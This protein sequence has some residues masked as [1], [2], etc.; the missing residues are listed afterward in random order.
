MLHLLPTD[1]A[2][3]K[4]S[5]IV[6][7]ALLSLIPRA[8]QAQ[9][10]SDRTVLEHFRDSLTSISDS[11]GLLLLEK[12][13]ID[14]AKA[15]RN[16]AV[17]H[18]KLGFVSLRLGEMGGHSHYDDAASEFQWAIDLQPSWPYAWYG[19][20]LAEYGVGDSQ[21]SFVTGLKTMLG[22]D[23]LTRSAVA[24]AKSAEVD[25][26][27]ARGLVDLANTALRQRVNIKL[28]VALDALRRAGKTVAGTDP[29]VLLA[30]GRVEREV[31]DGDSA[32]A[33]FN[34][35]L[36]Y[37][38]N[39]SLG[40]LELAR[41]HF[42]L[43]RF[44][45]VAA[46]FE[47]AAAD[48]STTVASYRSDL[49]TIA[50][51]STLREF[52]RQRGPQRVAYLKR[53]W[54]QRDRVELRGD[55]ERLRE[56]YRRLFYARKNFQLTTNNRHYDIVER[57]RSGSRDFDDRGVIYIRHGEPSS[58]ATYAAPGL[59]PNESWRYIRPD[60]D[61]I[62]HFIAR[63]DVQDFK[64]VESLFDVLG[65]SSAV[66]LQGQAAG[67]AENAMASQLMLSREQLSPIYRRL[68]GAGRM[69]TGRY[70][71]QERRVGQESIAVGT[72]S[73]SYELRF[74]QP[75]KARS[76]VLA[77]GRDSNG[78]Q[79]Q[80][81]YAIAGSSLEP[82]TVTR[83]YLY[84]VRL[85]FVALDKRGQVVSSLDTTRHFVAPAP[86]PPKEHL[87]GRVGT[88]VPRGALRYRLAIQQGAA[89]GVSLPTDSVRVGPVAPAALSLSDL[90]LGSRSANL[91]WRR[92]PGDTV[93]FNPLRTYRRS[94]EME[95]YYEIDG[96]RPSPY[97]VEL[98]VKRKGSSG[99]L[100]RKIFG[101]GGAAIRLKFQ[102]QATTPQVSTHRRLQLNRLKPGNYVLEI[103]VV[104]AAGRK[105][106]R[107][108]EF[109]VVE[110][111]KKAG[112][113]GS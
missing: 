14:S 80:I 44:D 29:E 26:S 7:I 79:V 98:V 87:V 13:L 93:L 46:Y 45:G 90:V 113:R 62:F 19:M 5:G 61:L 51:D 60:G 18:L 74:P 35:Y 3:W 40:L 48:D 70:Q 108:R 88:T 31:G 52:D 82:V 97:T 105:D 84:S 110:E 54:T 100:F 2:P 25:P 83:G 41:T 85:R 111:E 24:F 20:G 53:F 68:Q 36:Q 37:G 59:D 1:S 89:A 75:L 50:A 43:G 32:L 92:T 38:P 86:V 57:Y 47:G 9:T 17:L 91:A 58:R 33:A 69:S 27:F 30:R 77:V 102:E 15:D 73:D 96:L 11:S 106:R 78:P 66:K 65:F 99:G 21:V 95:L 67:A 101:G 71:S 4:H 34:G 94:D 72:T 22:K 103:L 39:R 10:P 64:L 56:H 76:E 8:I 55:G 112:Q 107:T 104:D 16:N 12:S 49:A 109:Q 28:G 81:A 63:E 6:A 23:A 42:L